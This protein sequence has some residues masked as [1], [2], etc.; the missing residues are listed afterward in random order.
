[1]SAQ[2]ATAFSHVALMGHDDWYTRHDHENWQP[3]LL[4]H[5]EVLWT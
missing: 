2:D 4:L 5:A 3:V 1:M